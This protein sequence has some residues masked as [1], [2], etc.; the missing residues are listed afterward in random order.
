MSHLIW[1]PAALGDVERLY[2]FLLEKD[3]AAARLAVKTIR[4]GVNIL[5]YKPEIGRPM[6]D[7][8]PEFREWLIDFGKNGYVALYRYDG[9]T[10]V[11]LAIRHQKEA[12]YS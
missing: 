11:I 10:A 12:G 2:N 4:T 8:P 6:D 5:A 7:M 1:S 3:A 9:K